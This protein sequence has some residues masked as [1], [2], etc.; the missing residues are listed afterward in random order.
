MLTRDLYD[1]PMRYPCPHCGAETE[2]PGRYFVTV[3]FVRCAGCEAQVS[4]GYDTKLKLF[5][6]AARQARRPP[7]LTR[8]RCSGA[9]RV[10]GLG[11]RHN[12][13]SVPLRGHPTGRRCP[14]AAKTSS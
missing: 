12:L 1:T 14:P 8:A 4:L 11:G 6:K 13:P 10:L 9:Q 7:R 2:R 3:R 5:E